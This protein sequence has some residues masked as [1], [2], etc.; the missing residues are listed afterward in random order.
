MLWIQPGSGN[1]RDPRN[2]VAMDSDLS[3]K[4]LVFKP[5]FEQLGPGD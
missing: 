4:I 1:M 5:P 2:E 3:V